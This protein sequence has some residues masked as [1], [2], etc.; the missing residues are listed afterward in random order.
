[1]SGAVDFSDYTDL[2]PS[3]TIAV[4]QMH[5]RFTADGTDG[6]MKRT[7][8]GTGEGLDVEYTLVDGQH[9]KRKFFAFM[10]IVGTSDG[11]KQMAD[12]NKAALKQIIDSARFL[13]PADKSPEMRAKRTLTWRDFDGLRFLAEIGIETGKNGFPDKN[14]IARV[15]T[16]DRPEWNNRAPI[17]QVSP[18][19]GRSAGPAPAGPASAPPP[20]TKPSWAQ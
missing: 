17:D 8:D 19:W 14:I 13:D 6:I 18:D 20:I 1:M 7:K 12:R 5:V 4:V 16:K 11:Q 15:I 3:G 9:A 10:L 2:I